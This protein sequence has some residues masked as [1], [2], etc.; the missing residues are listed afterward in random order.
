MK[1][2]FIF[3]LYFFYIFG[4]VFN[5]IGTWVDLIF[6]SSLIFIIIY[7]FHLNRMVFPKFLFLFLFIFVVYFFAFLISLFH[8][9]IEL[10]NLIDFF[11]KPI[12]IFVT[13]VGGYS[14]LIITQKKVSNF[15]LTDTL[16]Y[17]YFT[18]LFH[19]IIMILQFHFPDF[20]NFIYTYT[21]GSEPRST[22][23]YDFRMGGFSGSTGGAILSI[24]Q[25]IGIIFIPIL[26]KI[27][28]S[29][30]IK[31]F[32][33]FTSILILYSVFI[34]GRSGVWSMLIF[35]FLAI[36]FINTSSL[37]RQIW[38]SFKSALVIFFGILIIL[39][40]LQKL[41]V[42]SPLFYAL[43][44]TFDT[45]I[46]YS[47]SNNFEDET[48]V[49]LSNHLILPNSLITLL[50]GNTEVLINTQFE[51]NLESDIGYIRNLWGFGLFF[52]ILY[53]L[54]IFYFLFLALFKKKKTFLVKVFILIS[55]LI[56][57][58][59][60]KEIAFYTRMLFSIYSLILA[61]MYLSDKEPIESVN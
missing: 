57:L 32:L 60:A 51:R 19:A 18:I 25:S 39:S 3:I 33:Y 46:N 54:P 43:N 59:H 1:K 20:K 13:I 2:V 47:E 27:N 30:K 21:M 44:R 26:L 14:L 17:I 5:S 16:F 53:W 56:I 34:C 37:S 50:I 55:S 48:V 24:V 8:K 42:N 49:A 29:I 11:L 4:P 61:A 41:E 45:F 31:V 58:F 38:L 7:L 10:S 23:D 35:T 6:F 22:F 15:K 36:V 40:L 28:K 9:Y 12:R 52:S